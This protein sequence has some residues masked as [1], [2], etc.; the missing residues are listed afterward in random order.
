MKRFTKICLISC[1]TFGIL[2]S[3]CC[4]LAFYLGVPLQAVEE[5]IMTGEIREA[6]VKN[7]EGILQS[8]EKNFLEIDSIKIEV[9]IEEVEITIH[10]GEQ[11]QVKAENV[12]SEFQCIQDGGILTIQDEGQQ[13]RFH[14]FS[15]D[16]KPKITVSL[17]ENLKLEELDLDVKVGS[18]KTQMVEAQTVKLKCDIGSIDFKGKIKKEGQAECSVGKIEMNLEGLG[19]EYNYKIE[20]GI[21]SIEIEDIYDSSVVGKQYIDNNAEK[22]L[23]IDCGIGSV[24]V[25]FSE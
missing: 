8:V 12:S 14:M 19:Q 4:I 15:D 1:L 24:K 7:T 6:E 20:T 17:P 11:I 16:R 10:K 2:G 13:M 18:V 5:L 22:E 23:K 21:G 3:A 9:G 25:R